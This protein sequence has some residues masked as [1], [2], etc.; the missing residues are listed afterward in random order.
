MR[1]PPI[2]WQSLQ[3]QT[4]VWLFCPT[5]AH[6][7]SVSFKSNHHVFKAATSSC[8]D[9]LLKFSLP[10]DRL[11]VLE[12][13]CLEMRQAKAYLHSSYLHMDHP[14]AKAVVLLA[15]GV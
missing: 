2:H 10:P 15:A 14:E 9:V 1:T 8:H 7:F 4:D 3:C 11:Q 12:L 6:A 13:Q 5:E